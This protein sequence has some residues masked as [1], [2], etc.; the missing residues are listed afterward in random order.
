MTLDI[1]KIIERE[2]EKWQ[3]VKEK[4]GITSELIVVD[5]VFKEGE[6]NKSVTVLGSDSKTFWNVTPKFVEEL[7]DSIPCGLVIESPSGYKLEPIDFETLRNLATAPEFDLPFVVI[8]GVA[9]L[10]AKG[11]LYIEV[12]GRRYFVQDTQNA[13]KL[14]QILRKYRIKEIPVEMIALTLESEEG[15]QIYALTAEWDKVRERAKE[16]RDKIEQI[17]KLELDNEIPEKPLKW[18]EL[19][20]GVKLVFAK[21]YLKV[22]MVYEMNSL[23]LLS[24]S[25]PHSP[26]AFFKYKPEGSRKYKRFFNAELVKEFLIE[27]GFDDPK[28]PI[29]APTLEKAILKKFPQFEETL[30][31]LVFEAIEPYLAPGHEYFDDTSGELK[32]IGRMRIPECIPALLRNLDKLNEEHIKLLAQYIKY[33]SKGLPIV[34]PEEK[35]RKGDWVDKRFALWEWI[36]RRLRG[37]NSSL[38]TAFKKDYEK[39]HPPF[40]CPKKQGRECPF[41]ELNG[42]NPLCPFVSWESEIEKVIAFIDMVEIQAPDAI[43][44]YFGDHPPEPLGSLD[45][46]QPKI[47]ERFRGWLMATFHQHFTKFEAWQILHGLYDRGHF[48]ESE[49]SES[50]DIAEQFNTWLQEVTKRGIFPWDARNAKA[51]FFDKTKQVIYIPN[52]LFTS[53]LG[54]LGRDSKKGLSK[55]LKRALGKYLITLSKQL[56]T[57]IPESPNSLEMVKPRAIILKR[58]Y[59]EKVLSIELKEREV[60]EVTE[61]LPPEEGEE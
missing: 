25:F 23:S 2:K 30:E 35:L 47:I 52:P 37:D 42:Q 8:N 24:E 40:T 7:A 45:I 17:L 58:E 61:E 14:E 21:H 26:L 33:Y 48:K 51:L 6:F 46:D 12:D 3:K 50:I 57:P 9:K 34:P 10:S 4:L 53:F 18:N 13:K 38:L 56:S 15:G 27:L 11:R 1:S 43:V 31:D 59:F 44:I 41:L 36:I 39:A 28:R 29:S 55:Q 20:E 49:F 22:A 5:F 60:D 32:E 19:S 54:M 16:K